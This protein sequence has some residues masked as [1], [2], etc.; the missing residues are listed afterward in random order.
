MDDTMIKGAVFFDYDG[1]LV[2]EQEH[3]YRMTPT[4]RW[5]I[6]QLRE[7]G[8]LAILATGRAK[9]YVPAYLDCFDGMVTTN[10][11][12]AQ[13]HSKEIYNHTVPEKALRELLG[14]FEEH[15]IN[16]MIEN[17][18][19]AYCW[20]LDEHYQYFV[21]NFN[22]NTARIHDMSCW[23]P[24][25]PLNKLNI[26]YAPQEL[27]GEIRRRFAGDFEFLYHRG[28]LTSC[29]ISCRGV[30]KASGVTAVLEAFGIPRE[31]AWA[32]G[33]ND[34]DCEMLSAVGHGVAMGKHSANL[35]KYAQLITG[36]VLEEGIYTALVSQ[37][38]IDPIPRQFEMQ[39][40]APACKDYLWGGELLK[41]RF[42]K[43]SPLSPLAEC[44][45]LSTHPDGPSRITQGPFGGMAL[46]TFLK[47]Y[48][49]T[50]GTKGAAYPKFPMLIKLIDAKQN[51]SVQVH[52]DD[53]YAALENGELGKTEMWHILDCT[54]DA[55]LYYGVNRTLDR[56]ELDRRI[57]ENTVEEILDRVPVHK[58]DTFFIEAGTLHAI[59]A[60][61]LLAEVQQN[62]NT[63]Y[64]VYDYGRLGANGEPRQLHIRQALKVS[65]LTP[66]PM[67]EPD[68]P[69][70]GQ[71]F[72]KQRLGE[73][74]YFT[75]DL[76]QVQSRCTL[77]L[78]RESFTALLFEEGEARL[79]LNG[80]ELTAQKGQTI[81]LPAQEASLFIQGECQVLA[82]RV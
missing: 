13:V 19:N 50:V 33:D 69:V 65:R 77:S 22:I 70:L 80:K 6:R 51:L 11:A 28:S 20:K 23:N 74:A 52:P 4:T 58:G 40:L 47:N 21:S 30:S 18:E 49:E 8:Y 44:W 34:N 26:I 27:F 73:C 24:Q 2:D 53:R 1:T 72:T 48:P 12:Y 16:Y 67:R 43:E 37:G 56:A 68:A 46:D 7:N 25:I 32:F 45:E 5:C 62:S 9:C 31:N 41:T 38:L 15:D 17:Q 42:H 66:S 81:F 55:C 29:D 60:G 36:T 75:V 71:G 54:P 61:I 59:G 76:Y 39:P 10:G 35:E 63:T 57:R 82:A 3:L 14:Y 79:L 64:R 78:T